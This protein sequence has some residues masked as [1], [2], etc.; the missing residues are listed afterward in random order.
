MYPNTDAF[1]SLIER[2]NVL[3]Y[4]ITRCSLYAILVMRVHCGFTDSVYAYSF[5]RIIC[6]L[7]ALIFFWFVV[8][9]F[10][11]CLNPF[12]HAVEGRYSVELQSCTPIYHQYAV[13]C[14]GCFDVLLCSI[15]LALFVVPLV[16]LSR[17]GKIQHFKRQISSKLSVIDVTT[18]RNT[19][20]P[21]PR[22]SPR[23]SP[24]PTPQ[25]AVHVMRRSHTSSLR[26]PSTHKSQASMDTVKSRS[27]QSA[28]QNSVSMHNMKPTAINVKTLP[29]VSD[30]SAPPTFNDQSPVQ[31]PNFDQFDEVDLNGVAE[32]DPDGED[33]ELECMWNEINRDLNVV[34]SEVN[35]DPEIPDDGGRREAMQCKQQ[36]SHIDTLNVPTQQPM[37]NENAKQLHMQLQM[38]EMKRSTTY[39]LSAMDMKLHRL[40]TDYTQH[41]TDW[42][43]DQMQMGSTPP[44]MTG[45][46]RDFQKHIERALKHDSLVPMSAGHQASQ[47]M[48]DE[49]ATRYALLVMMCIG[50]SFAL[51]L[52][53]MIFGH[54]LSHCIS[55]VDDL[56]NVW[57]IILISKKTN[58]IYHR[59]CFVCNACM[60]ACCHLRINLGL[61][62][63][64]SEIIKK[65]VADLHRKFTMSDSLA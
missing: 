5:R 39:T 10:V 57:C 12:F 20:R 23:H 29:L 1:C 50:S 52:A 24:C 14:G 28:F 6:P 36:S 7:F 27:H 25:N 44:S 38:L 21:S 32:E 60:S 16:K 9:L 59:L 64:K 41:D 22:H 55:P 31:T 48:Y 13:I 4:E 54:N 49:L 19:P 40:P 35:Q 53:M 37:Q 18:A 17:T 33:V 63:V 26:T 42:H 11:I 61:K 3:L 46:D 62:N 8:V 30:I 43:D 47:S 51:Y 15:L 34:L 45:I 56:I 58:K 2:G 65:S